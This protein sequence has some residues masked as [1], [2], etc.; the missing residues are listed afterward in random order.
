MATRRV[1][2]AEE[3]VQA[4][5]SVGRVRAQVQGPVP[6]MPEDPLLMAF[7]EDLRLPPAAVEWPTEPSLP[8]DRLCAGAAWQRAG[9]P[10]T[11]GSPRLEER[12]RW[13]ELLV[14]EEAP[15][16]VVE[17]PAVAV[18]AL[19]VQ[20]GQKTLLRGGRTEAAEG[21]TRCCERDATSRDVDVSGPAHPA[22]KKTSSTC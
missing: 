21:M 22:R 10:T 1:M 17:A 3:L 6:G 12:G 8:A 16:V 9:P 13:R 2:E 14:V 7:V 11:E 4:R 5:G 15:A 19:A 18:E 20:E